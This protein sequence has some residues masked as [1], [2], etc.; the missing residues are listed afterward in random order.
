M[1]SVAA[2]TAAN[3]LGPDLEGMS[4]MQLVPYVAF[5]LWMLLILGLL[6]IP[7]IRA[8]LYASLVAVANIK[9]G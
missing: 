5:A 7:T 9:Q 1:I 8:T 2:A 4:W 6:L 3:S